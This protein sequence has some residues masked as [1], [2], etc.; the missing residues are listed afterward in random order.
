MNPFLDITLR[1]LAVYGFM[2]LGLRIFGKNQLSQLN[3]G[4]II[5]LL[6]ISNAV[7]NAMVGQD[8][9]LQ[10]GLVAA[11]VLFLANFGLKKL[12]FK[13]YKIKDLIEA[14]PI[15]LVKD[16]ILDKN[17]LNKSEITID[18]LEDEGLEVE[19]PLIDIFDNPFFTDDSYL[20]LDS[21]AVQWN[22]VIG[23]EEIKRLVEYKSYILTP[24]LS[25]QGQNNKFNLLLYGPPG[26]GKTYFAAALANRFDA[27][28]LPVEM[29]RVNDMFMYKA[30]GRIQYYFAKMRLNKPCIL[31]IDELERF[32][33]SQ[34]I[35]NSFENMQVLGK[36]VEELDGVRY[37]NS[38]Q[39]IVSAT[40][41]P[42]QIEQGLF[43]PGKFGWNRFVGPPTYKERVKFFESIKNQHQFTAQE[44]ANLAGATKFFS[45]AELNH[46]I[47]MAKY[48][49][50]TKAGR[51][52]TKLTFAE[53]E[54]LIA[55]ITPFAPNWI[56]IFMEKAPA[57][58]LKE[59]TGFMEKFD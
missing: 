30:E 22:K 56:E 42:W 27:S 41:R 32:G 59:V 28:V 47:D 34:D 54:G 4:D 1:S 2:I 57:F 53:T 24:E 58:L 29:D 38:E 17:A 37:K 36:L 16:G 35:F 31:I 43:S 45:F 46:L 39:F 49:A 50:K 11:L 13:N 14:E 9:S 23:M 18:E 26:C 20:F 8:T 21:N 48:E 19:I 33:T 15:I 3:A 40:N 10:G 12:M 25:K 6:L 51:K 44:I 52:K 55:G 5:L 7:Q